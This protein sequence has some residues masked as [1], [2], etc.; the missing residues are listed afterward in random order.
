MTSKISYNIHAQGIKNTERLLSHLKII[1]PK[2][3][4]VMDGLALARIIKSQNPETIVIHR[5]WPDD[6]IYL[7]Q[8]PTQWLANKRSQVG[9]DDIWLYTTNEPGYDE[10]IIAWH[11]ELLRLNF[12]SINPLRLVILN[13]SSGVPKPDEWVKAD[14]L[15]KLASKYKDKVIIG[16][17]EYFGGIA[18][19]GF[20]GGNPEDV[21]YHPN[22]TV[23]SNWPNKEVAKDLTKYHCG[24]FKFMADYCNANNIPV[25]RVLLTEHGPDAM[26]DI[27]SWLKA[28]RMTSP[29][30]TIRGFKTLQNQWRI[31]FP[32]WSLDQAYF[33]QLKYLSE[34]IYTNSPVEAQMIFCYGHTS[35]A[36]WEQFDVENSAEFMNLLEKYVGAVQ[37]PNTN[38]GQS[39]PEFPSDFNTRSVEGS[40]S[41]S[42]GSK[43]NVRSKPSI[44][45]DVNGTLSTSVNGKY[46][47]VEKMKTEEIV[48]EIINGTS[49]FWM[50]I[51]INNIN[52]W[53]FNPFI[54][55]EAIK[56]PDPI[57]ETVP[58]PTPVPVINKAEIEKSLKEFELK[59][60]EIKTSLDSLSLSISKI[61][62][63]I[64]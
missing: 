63:L 57:P 41:S 17:H 28:L 35:G 13:L 33:E 21:R 15:L 32:D 24:R 26:G 46:I 16:L 49:G 29:Y 1:K 14:G 5:E 58:T 22:Y 23:R 6:D 38:S 27:D 11:E 64:K 31:W 47:P 37:V 62:E 54:K 51:S 53:I 52:G 56:K 25:P 3:V 50:A 40:I 19:S 4:V 60:S 44:L 36:Q 34:N 59:I 43:V 18:T 55:I 12:A 10:R 20:V 2:A 45:G 42:S 9:T 7:R 30:N 8:S 61:R 48:T 39:L